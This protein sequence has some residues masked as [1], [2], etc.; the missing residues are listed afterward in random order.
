MSEDLKPN[1]T[2]TGRFLG[3]GAQSSYWVRTAMGQLSGALPAIRK[4][5]AASE[6]LIVESNSMIEFQQPDLYLVVLD[7]SQP[8][9][10]AS[11]ARFLGRADACVTIE[12]DG[13]EP[14]WDGVERKAWETKPRFAVRPPVY[15]TTALTEFV[16]AR[17]AN[18]LRCG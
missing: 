9:F 15:V 1:Q 16:G 4:V 3:A 8:D 5:L 6:N 2:D 13:M 18:S 17:L 11:S 7:F 12:R 10:K 14:R